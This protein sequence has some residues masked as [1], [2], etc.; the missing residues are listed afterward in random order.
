MFYMAEAVL[1]VS[2][3]LAVVMLG[4]HANYYRAHI[5]PEVEEFLHCFWDMMAYLANTTIF[6]LVGVVIGE[7]AF[8]HV[9]ASDWFFL[10]TLYFGVTVIR[11]LTL[12][13]LGPLLARIGYGISWQTSVVMTWGGLRGAVGLALALVVEHDP[14]I[15]PI[16]GSKIL[17]HTAGIVL[18]TLVVNATTITR[19][20]GALKFSEV[21]SSR[22]REMASIVKQLDETRTRLLK[23]QRTDRFLS[24]A[25]WSKV[26]EYSVIVDPYAPKVD[27]KKS[28][29]SS[30]KKLRANKVDPHAALFEALDM[31]PDYNPAVSAELRP[32]ELREMSEHARVRY[33]KAEKRS[34]WRQYEIGM[35]GRD[36]VRM[37]N[38]AADQ[39]IDTEGKLVD[40]CEI[41]PLIALPQYVR[42]MQNVVTYITSAVATE[43]E[44]PKASRMIVAKC[45]AI[46]SSLYFDHFITGVVLFNIISIFMSMSED[47]TS[48]NQETYDIINY[49]CIAIY[50]SEVT[51]KLTALQ[52]G[53]FRQRWNVFDLIVLIFSYVDIII[54]LS[55]P[56]RA[57]DSFSPELLRI[58]R[59]FK[60][61]RFF[62]AVRLIRP[63]A[64]L[65]HWA[66][67]HVTSWHV[68]IGYDMG[69]AYVLA[70][71]ETNC[72]IGEFVNHEIIANELRSRS[73]ESRAV[74][75][76][77]MADLQKSHPKIVLAVKTR[78]ASR[79]ILNGVRQEVKHLQED[80]VMDERDVQLLKTCCE[81]QMKMLLSK[82]PTLDAPDPM[83]LLFGVTWLDGAT[84]EMMATIKECAHLQQYDMNE[85]I[86]DVGD[87]SDGIYFVVAGLVRITFSINGIEHSHMLG[88]GQVIGELGTLTDSPRSAGMACETPVE[89][90]YI[91]RTDLL[92]AMKLH[93]TLGESLWRVCGIRAAVSTLAAMPRYK[94][95]QTQKLK[96]HC[97][98][99]ELVPMDHPRIWNLDDRVSDGVVLIGTATCTRTG[100]QFT[101]M[102]TIP[103]GVGQVE[104]SEGTQFLIIPAN[105][106]IDVASLRRPPFEIEIINGVNTTLSFA[107]HVDTVL[108]FT[109]HTD[110]TQPS[111]SKI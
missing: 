34:Y 72:L 61:L 21:S 111:F 5:S 62:R 57:N 16:I 48:A 87:P 49:I 40:A 84:D 32:H 103:R 83:K 98:I 8:D 4:L 109:S 19:L 79:C 39:A 54:T 78:Q 20:L 70:R 31:S 86:G 10:M 17:F 28:K 101:A 77:M 108:S 50:T 51:V 27:K 71:E 60:V 106:D 89:A 12:A 67:T 97:E 38:A 104:L 76:Q 107:N 6:V 30:K 35:L 13:M 88:A 68:A 69:K 85:V 37:L 47:E 42:R 59:I 55:L 46:S 95:W 73:T 18:L 2:G 99:A 14:I 53:Y 110:P 9:E 29:R 90:F 24:D 58:A 45:Q 43:V 44:M 23:D 100:K 25:I 102:E 74:V 94:K 7:R 15:D 81:T 92:N 80:G 36:A 64:P 96:K 105:D 41:A 75:V 52:C 63:A 11:G 91:R 1:G 26:S 56:N 66:M 93:P 3:V 22:L 82:P 65:M 33:L